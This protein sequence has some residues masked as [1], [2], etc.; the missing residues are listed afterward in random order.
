MKRG[1]LPSWPSSMSNNRLWRPRELVSKHRV[2]T[3]NQR[4][5]IERLS[6]ASQKSIRIWILLTCQS[7][8]PNGRPSSI[9]KAKRL[10]HPTSRTSRPSSKLEERAIHSSK[11]ISMTTSC[12]TRKMTS[13]SRKKNVRARPKK[14]CAR[15]P[16]SSTWTNVSSLALTSS[17]TRRRVPGKSALV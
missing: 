2:V 4:P 16:S 14:P 15:L 3:G 1:C 7:P 6:L 9:S 8:N 17:S 11:R 5:T 12:K 13:V 10:H